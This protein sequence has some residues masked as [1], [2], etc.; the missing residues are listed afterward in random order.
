M[1][2][3]RGGLVSKAHRPVY[4]ST[5]GMRVI[6]RRDDVEGF[7]PKRGTHASNM[8]FAAAA[9]SRGTYPVPTEDPTACQPVRFRTRPPTKGRE[10]ESPEGQDTVLGC[11]V[12]Q[13]HM[14]CS[15]DLPNDPLVW[16][17][18]PGPHA[19][20]TVH[21]TGK[22]FFLAFITLGTGPNQAIEP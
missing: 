20:R 4:H 18:G 6:K 12:L 19:R 11:R 17:R 7:A 8:S 2:R 10:F 1:Q 22:A 14:T 5:L 13:G 16:S 21:G 15:H 3:F 9:S